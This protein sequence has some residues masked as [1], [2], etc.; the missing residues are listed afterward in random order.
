MNYT[1]ESLQDQLNYQESELAS[2]LAEVEAG[3][4][5]KSPI[6]TEA[7]KSNIR[8]LKQKIQELQTV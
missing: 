7:Y 4:Q 2:F 3:T 6:I 8:F 5:R 1:I